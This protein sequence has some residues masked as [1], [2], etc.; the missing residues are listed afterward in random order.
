MDKIRIT[1]K[2]IIKKWIKMY[3]NNSNTLKVINNAESKKDLIKRK[4][5][6]PEELEE[7]TNFKLSYLVIGK[8]GIGKSQFIKSCLNE[9]INLN[10]K[11]LNSTIGLNNL[12]SEYEKLNQHS[13]LQD[14]QGFEEEDIIKSVNI[15]LIDQNDYFN[16]VNDKQII[17]SL[18][19]LNN[20]NRDMLIILVC[21]E[22]YGLELYQN[23]KQNSEILKLKPLTIEEKKIIF[24]FHDKQLLNSSDNL[25]ILKTKIKLFKN[26]V[27]PEYEKY[28][29]NH[30][31]E[32]EDFD[33]KKNKQIK[34]LNF[35]SNT[36]DNLLRF[37]ITN[38]DIGLFVQENFIPTIL[39][40]TD[41]NNK[42]RN[43]QIVKK[44]NKST[45]LNDKFRSLINIEQNW[46]LN[47]YNVFTSFIIPFY[48]L[49]KMNLNSTNS[50]YF[51][52]PK[53]LSIQ[54]YRKRN[55]N[56]YND[57]KIYFGNNIEY[58]FMLFNYIKKVFILN[59]N[60]NNK[61]LIHYYS[62]NNENLLLL[63]LL[64]KSKKSIN[65]LMEFLQHQQEIKLKRKKITSF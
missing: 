52:Y 49:N 4:L 55:I 10:I 25:N 26:N 13:Q 2:I 51:N 43:R 16:L 28:N 17:K 46:F 45:I 15:L 7:F 42:K 38:K 34:S 48:Y 63:S 29:E 47:K 21:E 54:I 5:V 36:I 37:K 65:D 58:I 14:F 61:N 19:S 27:Y 6:K 57:L 11:Y 9:N 60:I 30:N 59:N 33:I 12:N 39:E 24:D 53:V 56:I 50:Q 20:K 35:Q 8:Y 44:I 18:L 23:I 22:E 62:I 1:E 64:F 32:L 41:K 3:Q 40:K 31:L